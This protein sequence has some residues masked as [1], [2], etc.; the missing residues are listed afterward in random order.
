MIP[1]YLHCDCFLIDKWTL[2]ISLFTVSLSLSLSL[3]LSFSLCSSVYLSALAALP[4]HYRSGGPP[5]GLG[6]EAGAP[7]GVV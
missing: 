5:C 2:L 4:A 3:F 1:L 6:P 7:Q